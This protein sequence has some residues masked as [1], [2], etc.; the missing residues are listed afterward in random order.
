MQYQTLAKRSVCV[1]LSG[2]SEEG[3]RTIFTFCDETGPIAWLHHRLGGG[4]R[5]ARVVIAPGLVRSMYSG[6]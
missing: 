5:R 6:E 4:E 1:V 2:G 3:D